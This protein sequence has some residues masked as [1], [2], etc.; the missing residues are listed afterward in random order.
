MRPTPTPNKTNFSFRQFSEPH[1][2]PQRNRI[3]VCRSNVTDAMRDEV[4]PIRTKSK[5]IE[6]RYRRPHLGFTAVPRS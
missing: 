1:L 2:D 6:N 3:Y 4:R 5:V